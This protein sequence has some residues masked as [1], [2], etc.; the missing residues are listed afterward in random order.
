[1]QKTSQSFTEKTEQ[2]KQVT[3]EFLKPLVSVT[4][5]IKLFCQIFMRQ[6][7]HNQQQLNSNQTAIL[8]PLYGT[9]QTAILNLKTFLFSIAI[10][11]SSQLATEV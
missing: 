6:P 3:A 5:P 11:Y 2:V 1:M 9:E 7:N 8:K 4:T 10:V